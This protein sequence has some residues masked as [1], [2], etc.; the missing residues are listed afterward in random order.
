MQ[1]TAV[2]RT[3]ERGASGTLA[4][5]T[6]P[7]AA[8]QGSDR[9]WRWLTLSPA[10]LLFALLTILPLLQLVLMSVNQVHWAG[11]QSSWSFVGLQHFASLGADVLFRAAIRNTLIFAL[12]AV[13]LQM[14]IGFAL[15]LMTNE[16]V[17]GKVIYRT[18]FLLPILVPGI[19]IGAIWKLMLNYDFGLIN[20]VVGL[21]GIGPQ[22]WLGDPALA[23]PSIIV[24]DIWHW[25][26]FCFLLLL[27]GLQ[28]LPQE[29]YEAATID[30]AN[31]WQRLRHVTLPLMLPAI[32]VTFV[33]RLIVAFKVFDE[34]YL[35]T[36]GG[37]GTSTEVI[38]YTIY[39]RFFTEDR[40]GYGSAMSIVTFFA[41][42]L[43]IILAVALGR[44][45]QGSAA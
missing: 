13:A 33:F 5:S 37:P 31:A 11:G 1:Q 16:L 22:D 14:L 42:G 4:A 9:L 44:R 21:V 7:G 17:R 40:V 43:L 45:R 25:T 34:V 32:L 24:V 3:A 39:R 36:G 19:V 8:L 20:Q 27:A 41:I 18:I 12:V 26:P 28:G 35:L 38:S 6:A 29:V 2:G 23:L 10:L 30:G 15:A